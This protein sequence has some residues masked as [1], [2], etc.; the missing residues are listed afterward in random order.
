MPSIEIGIGS[1]VGTQNSEA[2]DDCPPSTNPREGQA[3]FC[4]HCQ[5]RF[6]I[7]R[8]KF[9]FSGVTTI[10]TCPNCAMVSTERSRTSESNNWNFRQGHA[11]VMDRFNQWFKYIAAVLIGA[12]IIAAVLR[13]AVHVYGGFAREEIRTGALIAIPAV[14]LVII[15]LRRKR[16]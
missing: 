6:E 1:S 11:S 10:A 4:P 14:L 13:H 5:S 9:G 16:A 2:V 3:D 7:V 15:F 8:L 12:A